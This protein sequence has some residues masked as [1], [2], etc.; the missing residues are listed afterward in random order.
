MYFLCLTCKC[1]IQKKNSETKINDS[2][3]ASPFE[4][5]GFNK[6]FRVERNH[7]SGGVMLCITEDKP[8]KLLSIYKSIKSS[9]LESNLKRTKWLISYSYN[10]N[11]NYISIYLYSISNEFELYSSEFDNYLKVGDFNISIQETAMKNVCER[12]SLKNLKKAYLSQK[13]K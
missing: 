10:S 7:G 5:D 8:V 12:Y 1:L 11:R 9:L 13:P 6:P 2:S 4:I 3:P